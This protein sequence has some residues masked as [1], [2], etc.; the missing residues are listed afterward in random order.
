[1]I[2][3]IEPLFAANWAG[4]VLAIVG[5]GKIRKLLQRARNSRIGQE[6]Y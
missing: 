3:A 1:M 2:L 4:K 6:N 5:A